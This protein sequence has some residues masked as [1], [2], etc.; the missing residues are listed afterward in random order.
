MLTILLA[1][2][3]RIS[4]HCVPNFM[5]YSQDHC[6]ISPSLLCS[7]FH[8]LCFR[9]VLKKLP[10]YIMLNIKPITTAFMLQFIYNFI[11]FNLLA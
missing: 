3:S 11:I 2:Y 1:H 7:I 8:L 9:A 6:Q 10:M 5:H 4:L